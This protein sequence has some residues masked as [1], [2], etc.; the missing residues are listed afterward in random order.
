MRLTLLALLAAAP[1]HAWTF[2]PDPVCT[3]ANDAAPGVTV[4]Y[5][6]AL[7]AIH[8]TRAAGW[9]EGP[10]FSIRFDPNGP[11][12]STTRHTVDG[13]TLTVRD[14][15]FGNVL[16]GLQNNATAQAQIGG[17]SIPID[18]TGAAGPVEA[19]RACRPGPS[20]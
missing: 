1:V 8:L 19:F 7:Y 16:N 6:G 18:L 11:V 17:I 10:V 12:I 13:T 4:T 5:D 9:P 20:V 15:G 3:L 14:T 2:T